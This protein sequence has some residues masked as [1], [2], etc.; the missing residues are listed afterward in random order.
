MRCIKCNKVDY[1][2]GHRILQTEVGYICSTCYGIRE[3]LEHLYG[4]GLTPFRGYYEELLKR[5]N[6]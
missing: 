3:T 1:E 4:L 2:M 5:R 6:R